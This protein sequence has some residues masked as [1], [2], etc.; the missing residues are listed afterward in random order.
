MTAENNDTSIK[1]YLRELGN[2]ALDAATGDQACS[3]EKGDRKARGRSLKRASITQ[4][5]NSDLAANITTCMKKHY[6]QNH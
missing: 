6:E 1:V 5:S 2:P 4:N 3:E